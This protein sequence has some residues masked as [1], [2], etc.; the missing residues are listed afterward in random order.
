MSRGRSGGVVERRKHACR[1]VRGVGNGPV[2]KKRGNIGVPAP[3]GQGVAA[4]RQTPQ[5]VAPQGVTDVTGPAGT[6]P[7]TDG[8][9]RCPCSAALASKTVWAVRAM[10]ALAIQASSMFAS[11]AQSAFSG[12]STIVLWLARTAPC[13]PLER[14]AS[15]ALVASDVPTACLYSPPHAKAA[16]CHRLLNPSRGGLCVT[17]ICSPVLLSW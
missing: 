14:I 16:S 11:S 13:P 9:Q 5:V 10:A 8:P 2:L 4:A 12:G 7:A 1:G 3:T 6:A 17:A 15:V